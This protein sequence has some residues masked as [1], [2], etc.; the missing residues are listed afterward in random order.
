[1]VT[2]P[3]NGRPASSTASHGVPSRAFYRA[4]PSRHVTAE[5]H[6]AEL[7]WPACQAAH[8]MPREGRNGTTEQRRLRHIPAHAVRR[9]AALLPQRRWLHPG[10][11]RRP[12]RLLGVACGRDRDLL[13]LAVSGFRAA[14][15][16]GAEHGRRADAAARTAEE[17]PEFPGVPVLV[18]GLAAD[19]GAGGAAARLGEYGH[20]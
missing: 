18:Q 2:L 7:A 13:P 20:P 4:G 10:P 14:L 19:R 15:R 1:M 17:V 5:L 9:G 8:G 11:A 6:C 3:R 12:G 16:R